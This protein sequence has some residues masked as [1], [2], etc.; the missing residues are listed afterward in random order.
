MC[1]M[2][3]NILLLVAFVA[4]SGLLIPAQIDAQTAPSQKKYADIVSKTTECK[5]VVD[6][7]SNLTEAE[8]LVAKRKCTTDG[9]K[10]FVG[11][12]NSKNK[13]LEELK[14]K[15]MLQC[16]T[17]YMHYK[18]A[19]LENFKVLKPA[20]LAE[21]C[22]ALYSD[23]I[24]EYSGNDRFEK[25]IQRADDLGL[26]KIAQIKAE[27]FIIFPPAKQVEHGILPSHVDC[28]AGKVLIYKVSTGEPACVKLDSVDKIIKRLWGSLKR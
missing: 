8:K 1:N 15:N 24:W 7:N 21:D 18:I 25:L 6:S 3:K 14:T 23:P 12:V 20:Q 28:K 13:R 22:I 2:N 11:E 5:K 17:W 19:T 10:E 27:L 16:E 4:V 9:A 26:F